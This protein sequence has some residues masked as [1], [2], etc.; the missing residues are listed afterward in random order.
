M[1]FNDYYGAINM[2]ANPGANSIYVNPN[3]TSPLGTNAIDLKPEADSLLAEEMPSIPLDYFDSLRCFPNMGA[4]ESMI[5]V[6]NPDTIMI[7]PPSIEPLCRIPATGA[8]TIYITRAAHSNGL[9]WSVS[10]DAAGSID[11]LGVMTWTAGFTGVVCIQVVALGCDGPSDTVKR[12]VEIHDPDCLI[13]GVDETLSGTTGLI[14]SGTAGMT[15]YQWS[16]TGNAVISGSTTGSSVS[17]NVGTLCDSTFILKL[18]VTDAYGCTDSCFKVVTVEDGTP[19]SFTAPA[20]VS[21]CVI[22]I[23]AAQY[24]QPTDDIT[25]DRPEY[26]IFTVG[27]DVLDLDP[28]TFSDNCCDPASLIIHWA[29][30]CTGCPVPALTGTGQPSVSCPTF[31]FN[32]DN[33]TPYSDITHT[34]TYT[35]E[36][37]HNNNSDPQVRNIIIKPRPQVDKVPP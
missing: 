14:Y 27:S 12:R 24:F 8:T 3:F 21:F 23:Q 6:E 20:A 29:I 10:N 19:P 36:D 1:N 30:V 13:T 11:N 2:I 37:C 7:K 18:I 33:T 31:Q 16:V 35:L 28:A 26:Y 17:V 9:R 15:G 25:P 22:D 34:I 32:G 4:I 5:P